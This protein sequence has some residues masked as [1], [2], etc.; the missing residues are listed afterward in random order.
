MN[1]LI[2]EFEYEIQVEVMVI[3]F[4]Q[5]L[6]FFLV[7]INFI[8]V[9]VMYCL[10]VFKVNYLV[11]LVDNIMNWVVVGI[12]VVDE[13]GKIIRVNKFVENMSGYFMIEL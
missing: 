9:I 1:K 7:I 5:G 13:G 12:L 11:D 3:C 6:V 2:V 10:W 8:L 4:Y